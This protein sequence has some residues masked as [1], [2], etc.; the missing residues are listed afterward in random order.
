MVEKHL[1]HSKD[2]ISSFFGQPSR[3]SD[4]YIWFFRMYKL[5]IFH[6]EIIFI[7]EEDKVIDIA[8]V[9][10]FLWFKVKSIY[11]FEHQSPEYKI[12]NF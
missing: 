2:E 6:E 5:N 4:D 1:H 12:L 11:Y 7:F 10:Y 8:L 9:I 3:K